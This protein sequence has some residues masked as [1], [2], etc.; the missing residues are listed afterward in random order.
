MTDLNVEGMAVAPS[1]VETII[2]YAVKEVEGVVGIGTP[3][4]GLLEMISKPA[5]PSIE[6]S[7]SEDKKIEV[8]LHISVKYGCV[9]PDVAA[10]VR[11]AIADA[12]AAQV[13]AEVSNVDVYIDGIE[14]V[15]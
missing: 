8:V 3:P 5:T 2:T 7:V 9:L 4:A 10:N 1:V 11:T 13:G 12:V 14:F 15:D 6:V